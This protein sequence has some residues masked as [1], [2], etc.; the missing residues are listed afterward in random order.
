MTPMYSQVNKVIGNTTENK[1]I[2]VFMKMGYWV[3]KFVDSQ[4]GQPCD[5]IAMGKG[6]IVF[7]DIKH[8]VGDKF[9]F[10][11]IRENQ[12]NSF[13]LLRRKNPDAEYLHCGFYI[14]FEKYNKWVWLDYTQAKEHKGI[15]YNGD[16]C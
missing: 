1:A 2:N 16:L 8:C 13:E 11:N 10:K 7:C 9:N 5:I 3:H 4:A 12:L 15:K 6:N 14:Y